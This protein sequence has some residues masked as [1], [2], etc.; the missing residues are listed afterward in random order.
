MMSML[1]EYTEIS[2]SIKTSAYGLGPGGQWKFLKSLCLGV[3]TATSCRRHILRN[4]SC[5]RALSIR[6][7]KSPP[8]AR[9]IV[10]LSWFSFDLAE[11]RLSRVRKP[12]I[13]ILIRLTS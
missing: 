10:K 2:V 9:T 3:E 7:G 8:S 13:A 12:D 6:Q 4:R 11:S 5:R 1:W